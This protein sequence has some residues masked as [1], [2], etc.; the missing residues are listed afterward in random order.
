MRSKP[1]TQALVSLA[2]FAPVCVL[3]L[4]GCAPPETVTSQ[5]EGTTPLTISTAS[6]EATDVTILPREWGDGYF[7]GFVKN[8]SSSLVGGATITL[9]IYDKAGVIVA[10]EK[11]FVFTSLRPG[12][13]YPFSI[14]FSSEQLESYDRYEIALDTY[15]YY[16]GDEMLCPELKVISDW[17]E[18]GE[19]ITGTLQNTS[20]KTAQS[21]SICIAGYDNEKGIITV[22]RQTSGVPTI[23]A[24]MSATFKVNLLNGEPS[25]ITNY[26]YFISARLED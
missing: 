18:K 19:L 22:D 1:I 8:V 14:W 20:Q 11:R 21:V 9:T 2:V 17:W 12:E 16:K 10:Q 4:T 25:K 23:P 6:V 3:L 24:G 5:P 26:E 13:R 15:Q 7:F